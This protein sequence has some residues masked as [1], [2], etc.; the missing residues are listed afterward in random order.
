[1]K[2]PPYRANGKR[3]YEWR[4]ARKE[5]AIVEQGDL[6]R[7]HSLEHV[8]LASERYDVGDSPTRE[9]FMG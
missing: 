8:S 6:I 5:N 2:N 4:N 1:M 7:A 9:E 3:Q